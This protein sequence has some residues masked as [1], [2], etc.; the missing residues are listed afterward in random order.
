MSVCLSKSEAEDCLIHLQATWSVL[1][2]S[3]RER[4]QRRFGDCTHLPT[5][6]VFC[7]LVSFHLRA[8]SSFSQPFP[9]PVSPHLCGWPASPPLAL[10]EWQNWLL[11]HDLRDAC[12]PFY[13]VS[14]RIS[15]E[16]H[17]LGP[18]PLPS[19]WMLPI[20]YVLLLPESSWPLFPSQ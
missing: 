19:A 10:R 17:F 5:P 4:P 12:C 14:T 8:P 18:V 6:G 9:F 7:L 1:L 13:T 15:Q 2:K 3:S 11:T 20:S 16:G